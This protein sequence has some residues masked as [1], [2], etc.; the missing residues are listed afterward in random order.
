MAVVGANRCEAIRG[1]VGEI[2]VLDTCHNPR[3]LAFHNR[4][5]GMFSARPTSINATITSRDESLLL[6]PVLRQPNLKAYAGPFR[7]GDLKRDT[8]EVALNR[9]R[10]A[11][12]GR[13]IVVEVESCPPSDELEP[14]PRGI[15]DVL[16]RLE[17]QASIAE[18]LW[19]GGGLSRSLRALGEGRKADEGLKEQHIK[20]RL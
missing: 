7:R 3:S 15:L 14:G 8:A 2:L 1:T 4:S 10:G 11:A 16:L 20:A 17:G 9:L 12:A 19:C 5:C 6:V 13:D 18:A